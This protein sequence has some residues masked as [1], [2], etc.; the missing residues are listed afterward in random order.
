MYKWYAIFMLIDLI[1]FTIC[2]IVTIRIIIAEGGRWDYEEYLIYAIIGCAG[3]FVLG[4]M[5][6]IVNLFLILL[7]GAYV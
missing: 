7:N 6:T 3:T 1:V 4:L 2:T 5:G